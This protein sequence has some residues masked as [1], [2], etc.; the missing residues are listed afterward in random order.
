MKV[1][2]NAQNNMCLNKLILL[3][4]QPKI[5]M[6]KQMNKD[7]NMFVTTKFFTHPKS[8][9]IIINNILQMEFQTKWMF[10]AHHF[11]FNTNI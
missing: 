10:F 5:Q 4:L 9:M 2:I 1:I 11:F 6:L 7:H 8:L 3:E